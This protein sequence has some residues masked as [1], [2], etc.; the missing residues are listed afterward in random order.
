[1]TNYNKKM[2]DQQISIDENI[3][4]NP[5]SENENVDTI[6][7]PVATEPTVGIVVDCSRLNVRA[8]PRV[9]ANVICVIERNSKVVIDEKDSTKNFYKICTAVGVEGYCMKQ[10]VNILK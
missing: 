3:N 9:D 4:V 8:K 5:V 10:F 6:P 2:A 1:M 7:E